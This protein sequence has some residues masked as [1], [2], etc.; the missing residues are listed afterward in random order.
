MNLETIQEESRGGLG[1]QE[2]TF[3]MEAGRENESG[4]CK[5]EVVKLTRT[6]DGEGHEGT[7]TMQHEREWWRENKLFE[8]G[9]SWIPF[10]RTPIKYECSSDWGPSPANV[11]CIV[12]RI[13]TVTQMTFSPFKVRFH[14]DTILVF[15]TMFSALGRRRESRRVSG[16][17]LQ[18]FVFFAVSKHPGLLFSRLWCWRP[19]VSLPF[20]LMGKVFFGMTI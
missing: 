14:F 19:P 2:I 7:G 1:N 18:R 10:S 4:V 6:G 15:T 3:E 13:R 12:A 5:I 11:D 20:V 16:L 8:T 9:F 17:L